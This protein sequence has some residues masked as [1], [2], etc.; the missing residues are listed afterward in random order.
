MPGSDSPTQ[1]PG[2]ALAVA[3]QSLY[4][5]NLLLLPGLAFLGLLLLFMLNRGANTPPLARAHLDQTLWGS[6]WAGALLVLA[7]GAMVAVGGHESPWVWLVV[8]TYFVTCHGS[9]VVLG[10]LGLSRA[11]AA[12]CWRYPL[13]GRPLPTPCPG[14]VP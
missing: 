8:I 5:V 12:Q 13:V 4:L 9:L 1:V 14:K 6:L 10:A 2:Y 7:S 3:A 11:M